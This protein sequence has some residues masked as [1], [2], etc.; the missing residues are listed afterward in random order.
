MT[1][2]YRAFQLAAS[3]KKRALP[4]RGGA[5]SVCEEK[6]EFIRIGY[7]ESTDKREEKI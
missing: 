2:S 3:C 6:K 5:F 1:Q 7:K 4:D